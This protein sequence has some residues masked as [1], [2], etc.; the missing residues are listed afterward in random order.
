MITG[1]EPSSLQTGL[2]SPES[3]FWSAQAT[4]DVTTL[5]FHD[6]GLGAGTDLQRTWPLWQFFE[7][8]AAS[9]PAV[10]RISFPPDG[11]SHGALVR[12]WRYIF[13]LT[14]EDATHHPPSDRAHDE[15]RREDFALA[16]YMRH[17]RDRRQF[18]VAD[19]QGQIDLNLLGL[20]LVCDYRIATRDTVIVNGPNPLGATFGTVV[21]DLLYSIVGSGRAVKLLLREESLGARSALRLGIVHDLTRPESHEQEAAAIAARLSAKGATFLRALKGAMV[22]AATPL[23]SRLEAMGGGTGFNRIPAP[24][25]CPACEY[26]LTGHVSGWCPQCGQAIARSTEAS[27]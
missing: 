10:L 5:R 12:L 24:P 1:T 18:V 27:P 15:L 6:G 21:P 22:A 20:L 9:P 16:R 17:V 11:L 14:R 23:D 19:A 25:K 4:G 3:S 8:L 2:S 13:D 7:S 26:D